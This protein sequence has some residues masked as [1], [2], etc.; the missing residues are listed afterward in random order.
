MK[1]NKQMAL[2]LL[3][4]NPPPHEEYLRILSKFIKRINEVKSNAKFLEDEFNR[5][6]RFYS[7]D[8]ITGESTVV[9]PQRVLRIKKYILRNFGV[10]EYEWWSIKERDL[11]NAFDKY[12]LQV[13]SDIEFASNEILNEIKP[14]KRIGE[15]NKYMSQFFSKTKTF[16]KTL[17][18]D[19]IFASDIVI[20]LKEIS[21]VLDNT[22][23]QVIIKTK[24]KEEEV[25]LEYDLPNRVV[26]TIKPEMMVI[27][28]NVD[29][30]T[31]IEKLHP[32]SSYVDIEE[33]YKLSK[34]IKDKWLSQKTNQIKNPS[35]YKYMSVEENTPIQQQLQWDTITDVFENH[36][37][38]P[39]KIQTVLFDREKFTIN[40]AIK[41][42]K[43]N[44]LN[45]NKVDIPKTGK[46][47]RF[48]QFPPN[49]FIK[50]SYRTKP[51]GK[52]D[53]V[54]VIYGQPKDR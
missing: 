2:P 29:N 20:K 1:K 39:L 33:Q 19:D 24:N 8:P 30:F 25:K 18:N 36:Y 12:Y 48:R 47:L 54:L 53:G 3:R 7:S 40:S 45:Y 38:N 43:R 44:K 46:Y 26:V 34:I 49:Q 5:E 15:F 21:P 22:R 52:K 51:F 27:M 6:I 35:E 50:G 32:P 23:P 37:T 11:Y 42:L 28:I 17:K 4:Q 14:Q 31:R 10:S 13:L 41:F 9:E 16:F